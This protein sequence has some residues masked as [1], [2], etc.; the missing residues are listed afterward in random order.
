M[1]SKD[2]QFFYHSSE[3]VLKSYLHKSVDISNQ[4]ILIFVNSAGVLL[5]NIMANASYIFF[6]EMAEW[7]NAAVSKTVV[8]LSRDRGFDPPSL[9]NDKLQQNP[10]QRGGNIRSHSTAEHCLKSQSGKVSFSMRNHRTY[11]AQLNGNGTEISKS[12]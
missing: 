12:A 1:E 9:R 5:L 8:L 10:G 3:L 11:S 6:G 7:S 2:F 4:I